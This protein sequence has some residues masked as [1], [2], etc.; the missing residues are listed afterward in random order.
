MAK[1]A[2]PTPQK[3]YIAQA[4][5]ITTPRYFDDSPQQ[6]LAVAPKGIGV[7]QRV[8]HVPG[9]AYELGQR[10]DNFGQL[11]ESAACLGAT[12]CDVI[13]QVGTNWVH[14]QGTTPDDIRKICDGI[15]EKAGAPFLMAGLCIVEGL[16]A[17]GAKRIAVAN[18]YYRKDWKNGIN[19]FLE[20]AG[21][22][23]LWAG[24]VL[25]QG[26]YDSL[27]EQEEVE[28]LTLWDYP[29]EDVIKSC[30]LAHEAAPLADAVVQ[31]G[32]GFR[33]TPH[34]EAIEGMIGKPVVASDG[35]LYWAMLKALNLGMPVRGYGHLLGTLT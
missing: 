17:L 24:N 22:E 12:F 18:G 14:C 13:G 21:F 16:R 35:A 8:L 26:I 19:R 7:T 3:R 9:Y 1:N 25:D 33:V 5:F 27:E 11:E 15:G 20:Q 29:A 10:V 28:R 30:V 23:I 2:R 6:F 4:G 31:T 32:S 34:M